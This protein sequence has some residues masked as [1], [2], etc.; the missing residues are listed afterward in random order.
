MRAPD[1]TVGQDR[2]RLAVVVPA[3]HGPGAYSANVTLIVTGPDGGVWGGTAGAV[4]TQVQSV[5][6]GS[7][8]GTVT[9]ARGHSA[10]A[11]V[12]WTCSSAG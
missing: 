9:G 10:S 12:A 1:I 6:Q 2:V 11:Q 3:Y 8:S 4:A 5:T 7:F